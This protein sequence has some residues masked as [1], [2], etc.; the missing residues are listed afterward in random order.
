[1]VAAQIRRGP[2]RLQP[3]ANHHLPRQSE[4][5]SQILFSKGSFIPSRLSHESLRLLDPLCAAVSRIADFCLSFVVVILLLF[6]SD[7][8]RRYQLT[9]P[10]T[11]QGSCLHAHANHPSQLP[12]CVPTPTS[13]LLLAHGIVFIAAVLHNRE[14]STVRLLVH[15]SLPAAVVCPASPLPSP[16]SKPYIAPSSRRRRVSR[17]QTNFSYRLVVSGGTSSDGPPATS[18][19]LPWRLSRHPAKPQLRSSN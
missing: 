6:P 18:Q 11:K 17:S 3:S 15:D 9:T 5:R 10:F 1:M 19:L 16:P 14:V 2:S 7:S 8:T 12:A 13:C 4:Q